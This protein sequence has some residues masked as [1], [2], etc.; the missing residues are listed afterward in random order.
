M[1]GKIIKGIAG[2]YYIHVENHGIYECKAK[3]GFRNKKIK[4]YVGDLVEIDIIDEAHKKGN[5]VSILPRL[6]A[7]I[8]PTVANVDQAMIIFALTSPEPNL[9]LLDRFLI[10]MQLQGLKTT[11][12]FNKLDIGSDAAAKKLSRIYENC[13]YEVLFI[14]VAE[15]VGLEKVKKR[16]KGKTTVLAGPSG[17]GKSS[18]MNYLNPDA[19]METGAVSE[20]IQRGRHTT[21][22]SEIFYLGDGTYLMDTPGFT[23]LYLQDIEPEQLKDYF[24]E[25]EPYEGK[26]RFNGCVHI[27]EPDC[28]VKE[29]LAQGKIHNVRYESYIGLYEELKAQKKY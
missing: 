15:G 24:A 25:F 10:T 14:S 2:F 3:G 16:L 23:S 21:R 5:I 8:R 29:A 28:A 18:L 7:L 22:H 9:G 27:H 19:E 12:C 4:P 6:N 11:I 13:G 20:K 17:V 1:K 26:C